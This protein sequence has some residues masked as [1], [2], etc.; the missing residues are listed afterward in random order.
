MKNK[1]IR[2]YYLLPVF[3]FLLASCNHTDN[4]HTDIKQKSL[5]DNIGDTFKI[6]NVVDSSGNQVQL[7]FSKSDL[8]IIDFWFNDCPPCI[9]EMKQFSEV[10]KGKEAK[11]SIISISINQFW[12]WKST[13]V[14]HT[15]RFFFLNNQTPNWTQYV[16]KT[17]QDEKLRN[18][19]SADR[20]QE[21]QKLYNISFF[22]AY[23]VV[24]K[25]GVVLERPVSAAAYI[26]NLK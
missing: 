23:F 10:L 3:L 25:Q 8:T 14:N 7:D 2:Y 4:K 24:N 6:E 20:L 22:P 15:G 1:R 18:D 13:L 19:I 21:I 12:L 17:S 5:T 9:N 16:L 26:K 11:I